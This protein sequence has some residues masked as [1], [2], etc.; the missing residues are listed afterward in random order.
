MNICLISEESPPG[1]GAG[2]GGGGIGTYAY[3]L[4]RGLTELGHRVHVIVRGWGN[5][6]V[7]KVG[8][9][10]VYH[11]SIAEPSWRRGTYFFNARFGET[12]EILLWNLRVG[13][14]VR[15]INAVEPL[16]VIE[17]PE[18]HAQGLLAALRHRHI[19]MVVK[20]HTPAYLLSRVTGASAGWSRW[21]TLLSEHLEYRLVRRAWAVTSPSRKM[22][23]DAARQ[24]S[25]DASAIHVIPNMIDDDLFRPTNATIVGNRTLLYV[26]QV[27]RHKGVA[28]LVE[29]LP[30][31]LDAFP[32]IRVRL[33]GKVDPSE[34]GTS[35]MSAQLRQRLREV[36]ISEEVVEFVGP[37]D[38]TALPHLYRHAAVCVI[39]SLWESFGYSCLEAMAC[40]CAVVASAVGGLPEI[41]TDEAD[42]LLVPP[43]HPEALAA[44]VIRLLS[45]PLL[46]RRLG[47]R[48]RATVR[49]R[50]SLGAISAETARLYRSLL[51]Y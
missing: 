38:R 32:G 6:T 41:V 17:S 16:D 24:W 30:A 26:G 20:L 46:R 40:G 51:V 36:G 35:S 18:Y 23:E 47:A 29:A 5:E 49:N 12:R 48:A 4:A 10:R 33:V 19:P 22:A 50:F 8:D 1:M 7:H 44:A 9:A 13:Q 28:T 27:V 15:H 43:D 3:N 31:I 2:M 37:V 39:P 11:V 25:L 14:V 45:D 21:D 34:P 42:G